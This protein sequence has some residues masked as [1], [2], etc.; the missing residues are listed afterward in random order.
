MNAGVS[1]ME[2]MRQRLRWLE[3]RQSVLADNVANADTPGF[4]PRDVAPPGAGGGALALDARNARHIG[5]AG[6]SGVSGAAGPGQR[7]E[8]RPRGNAISLEDEMLRLSE[9]QIEHQTMIGLYQ[10]SLATL[11]TAIGRKV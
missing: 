10:R 7:F 5:A 11:K 3:A 9:V 1:T 6:G 8:T 2:M 4:A